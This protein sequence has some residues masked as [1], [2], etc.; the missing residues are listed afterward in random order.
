M[1]RI[2]SIIKT[3]SKSEMK[4]LKHLLTVFHGKGE[5]KLLELVQL[6]EKNPQISQNEAALKLY[7][8]IKSKAFVMTKGRLIERLYDL[9]LLTTDLPNSS[10]VEEDPHASHLANLHKKLSLV[11]ALR[12]RGLTQ[13]AQNLIEETLKDEMLNYYT[14]LKISY[15]ETLRSMI[16][17]DIDEFHRINRELAILIEILR[18]EQFALG[19]LYEIRILI[20]LKHFNMVSIIDFM[21][22]KVKIIEKDLSTVYSVRLNL[23]FLQLQEQLFE[24]EGKISESKRVL[25][26]WI[27]LLKNNPLVADNNRKS[28]AYIKLALAELN[29][30]NY[31]KAIEVSKE[32]APS[33]KHRL[34]NFVVIKSVEIY[35][36]FYIG[37]WEMIDVFDLS[38]LKIDNLNIY[39]ILYIKICLMYLRKEYKKIQ[40]DNLVPLLE[41]KQMHNPRLRLLEILI[42]IETQRIDI[43]IA[44]LEA[45]RKHLSKYETLPRVQAT[46]KILHQLELQSFN[47]QTENPQI[48]KMLE[49]L[50]ENTPWSPFSLEAIRFDTWVRAQYNRCNYWTQWKRENPHLFA[51]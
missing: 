29:E 15:L 43:A 33:I 25:Q 9:V 39:Y 17:N 45:L 50:E 20:R 48:N 16:S 19:V 6:I 44:K 49:E 24:A 34:N 18:V 7:Q 36:S 4:Y 5:N 2:H 46:Y 38:L 3:F 42:Y 8:D 22:N 23:A 40:I 10:L 31:T 41:N 14:S 30:K 21:K 27:G 35:S 32:I 26:E 37:E 51:S 1:E 28:L 47:F 13:I 11:I 12:K